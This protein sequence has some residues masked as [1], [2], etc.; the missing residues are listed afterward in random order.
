MRWFNNKLKLILFHLVLQPIANYTIVTNACGTYG[1]KFEF[2]DDLEQFNICC[3]VH[4]ICYQ[5]CDQTKIEC[6]KAFE[7]CLRKVCNSMDTNNQVK[8]L[9]IQF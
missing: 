7:E 5:A 1:F 2:D 4:D 6:D 3:D 9:G 8:V